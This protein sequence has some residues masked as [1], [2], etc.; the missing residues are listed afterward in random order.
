MSD[1][2]IHY[3]AR[4]RDGRL[5]KLNDGEYRAFRLTVPQLKNLW[6]RYDGS[7]S[8]GGFEGEWIHLALNLHGEGSYCAV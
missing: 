6:D 2:L 7:N 5:V 1:Y 3:V 8:P 4:P